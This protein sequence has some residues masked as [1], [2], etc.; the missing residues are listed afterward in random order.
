[1]YTISRAL[2]YECVLLLTQ[3]FV[4]AVGA[5]AFSRY[6]YG[7]INGHEDDIFQSL[8][9]KYLT[10]HDPPPVPPSVVEW[11][12]SSVTSRFSGVGW[13]ACEIIDP[14]CHQLPFLTLLYLAC[15]QEPLKN[16]KKDVNLALLPI[17]L[18]I[19][20]AQ[21][22]FWDLSTCGTMV[23][24]GPYH[25][26]LKHISPYDQMFWHTFPG[27]LF[28][29][30]LFSIWAGKKKEAEPPLNEKAAIDVQGRFSFSRTAAAVLTWGVVQVIIA[31][32]VMG[33]EFGVKLG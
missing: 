27:I 5:G 4:L 17:C 1:M 8:S 12:R 21:R 24:D 29:G 10:R 14:V 18:L 26:F 13:W 25:G 9:L 28:F 15:T 33:G 3:L 23:C 19:G 30:A 16:L 32:F 22:F 2:R 7:W 11:W 31:V 6:Y 20:P